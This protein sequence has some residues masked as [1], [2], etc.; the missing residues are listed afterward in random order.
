MFSFAVRDGVPP[1]LSGL[2][3]MLEQYA[4]DQWIGDHFS[5]E[6][7]VESMLDMF[8]RQLAIDLEKL[9]LVCTKVPTN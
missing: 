5:E 3:V 9:E 2:T 8:K 4:N 6:Q 1:K 7:A